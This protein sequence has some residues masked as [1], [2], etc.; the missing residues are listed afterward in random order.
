[1]YIR[2]SDSYISQ[3]L[4]GDLNR[5]LG[6]LLEQ[7]QIA[8][9]MRRINSF[10]DDPRAVSSIQRYRSL[11]HNNDQYIRDVDRSRLIVDATDTA[12]QSMSDILADVRVIALRE[13]S[14]MST[15][16]SRDM[17]VI[18]VDNLMSRLL[19]LV[20]TE[21]EGNFIFAGRELD[22]QPFVRN[23][24]A[25]FYMGDSDE[26]VSRIGPNS[27][28]AVNIPG[29]VLLG[30]R[31][32]LLIGNTDL[33]PQLGADTLL[34]EINLGRGW[35]P[36]VIEISDGLGNSWQIDL[37][38]AVTIDD[39]PML[40]SIGTG[41]AV[42]FGLTPDRSGLE[43]TG[44]GPLEISE[45]AEGG[46]ATSLGIIG[47]SD[48][49]VLGGRDIRA[50]ADPTTALTEI[51]S[52]FGN[53]PLGT[54]NV[55]WQGADYT[56]D[57]SGANNLGDL[58]TVFNAAISGLQLEVR[59][60]ALVVVGATPENFVITNA[61]ATNTANVLGINGMG[62]P[63]R[64]FG[65]LEDLKA[66][67]EAGDSQAIR[68][69]ISELTAVED[70]IYQ[71]LMKTG[72]RQRDLDWADG[73]LRQRDERLQ[74]NLSLE[75]DADMAEVAAGLSRA[76][77]TYQASLLVSSRMFEANLLMYLR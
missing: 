68:N 22:R 13:S 27:T 7:Q 56:V 62:T 77:T 38:S 76:E 23:E 40:I 30:T 53:L 69:S 9:S 67:L 20:N 16:S 6:R 58:T 14:A 4:V 55:E 25:V 10:A 26:Y 51:T 41:G 33:A 57:F 37:S 65:L 54:I 24:G 28:M 72:G 43:F 5:S 49:N 46:T 64:L 15:E 66:S 19:D 45:F 39:L 17:S 42:S 44:T 32:S 2:V 1:M 11:L 63:A 52:L 61:D 18:E 36:G 70:V 48:G 35:E 29:D 8:G 3:I 50:A 60:S 73:I 21:I 47:V 59:Q 34:S 74:A 12:L 71:L 75:Y 31:N